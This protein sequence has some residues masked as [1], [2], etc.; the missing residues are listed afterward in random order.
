[1]KLYLIELFSDVDI[2]LRIFDYRRKFFNVAI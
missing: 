2:L 1:M